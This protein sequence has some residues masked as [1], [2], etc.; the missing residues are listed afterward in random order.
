MSK[1]RTVLGLSFLLLASDVLADTIEY[2]VENLGGNQWQYNYT[3]DNTG[4]IALDAFTIFFDLGF[5][6][7]LAVTSSPGDWDSIVF[8]PDPG[9]PDDGIFDSL[10]LVGALEP[11][12]I[13]GGFSVA[14]DLLVGD[15]PG[16]QFFEFY[17]SATFDLI[18]DGFTTRAA[19]SVPEPATLWLFATGLFLMVTFAKRRRRPTLELHSQ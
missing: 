12:D 2:T 8:Q 19:T 16:D 14:F 1:I 15:S 7:N 4:L 3:V 5:Y 18:S 13:L 11:G 6:E 17:D 9:L 10:A